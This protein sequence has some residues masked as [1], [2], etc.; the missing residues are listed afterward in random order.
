MG[1]GG[2]LNIANITKRVLFL[3]TNSVSDLVHPVCLGNHGQEQTIINRLGRQSSH[4]DKGPGPVRE[5]S[6][7]VI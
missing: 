3:L 1:P 7:Q 4:N 2:E 6:D 5:L